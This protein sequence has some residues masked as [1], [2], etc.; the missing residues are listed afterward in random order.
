MARNLPQLICWVYRRYK[1]S[2]FRKQVV[3]ASI[4]A[5]V[6]MIWSERNNALWNYNIHTI[7][8][9]INTIQSSVKCRVKTRLPRQIADED[10]QWLY[11]L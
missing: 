1:G 7:D 4:M 5:N 2:K 3:T 6:Y 11:S 8:R 9:T 10:I